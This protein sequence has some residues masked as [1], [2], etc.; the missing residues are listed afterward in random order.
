[1]HVVAPRAEEEVAAAVAPVEGEAAA[2]AE[3]EVIKKGKP[4][5]E[6]EVKAAAAPERRRTP[7]RRTRRPRRRR[8]SSA[9]VRLV[10]GLGNPGE[11]Y[12]RTRHNL[13]FMVVDVLAARGN[14][15]AARDEGDAWVAEAD[16]AGEPR[17]AG[18]A[19]DVHEPQ[20]G[21][22]RAPAG[23]STA[24]APSDLVVVVDD[25][26]LELGTLRIRERGTHGGHNGL[27]SI[28]DLLGT[29]EFPRV[30]VGIRKG[31]P[32]E[33]LAGYVLSEFPPEDVLVVQ[34]IVGWAADAVACLLR[35]GAEEAMNR[36]NGPR[37]G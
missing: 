34:E 1:M 35:E 5:E 10:A 16:V 15:R 17:A 32:P 18:Q 22:H 13:G 2:G 19:A 26:A 21:A 28:I 14:A 37:R 36:Y 27:R 25:V 9:T 20:R 6:G 3:P 8:R 7:R 11:K 30:R 33:D 12:R 31:D 29:D 23:R 24:L 4:A